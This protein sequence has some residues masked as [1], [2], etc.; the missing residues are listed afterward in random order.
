MGLVSMS[1]FFPLLILTPEERGTKHKW[2]DV[3]RHAKT[4]VTFVVYHSPV[5]QPTQYLCQNVCSTFWYLMGCK[6]KERF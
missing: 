1:I 3:I 6:M 4:K 5:R 2:G